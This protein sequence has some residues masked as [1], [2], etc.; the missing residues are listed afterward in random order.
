LEK[1]KVIQ[2]KRSPGLD[3]F[4]LAQPK[5]GGNVGNMTSWTQVN[6]LTVLPRPRTATHD[7]SDGFR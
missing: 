6:V 2:Q 5:N 1:Q 3:E 7:P 4:F